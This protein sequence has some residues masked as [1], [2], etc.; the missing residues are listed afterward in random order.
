MASELR[1]GEKPAPIPDYNCT[2]LVKERLTSDQTVVHPRRVS[3]TRKGCEIRI[4]WSTQQVP[5]EE[6]DR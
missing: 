6:H 3:G 1:G 2:T 4:R 5:V